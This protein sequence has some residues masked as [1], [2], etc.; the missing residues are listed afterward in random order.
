LYIKWTIK[1]EE[2]MLEGFIKAV[3]ITDLIHQVSQLLR[4][5]LKKLM[6]VAWAIIKPIEPCNKEW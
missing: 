1:M 3:C 6:D 4:A 2:V 5:E